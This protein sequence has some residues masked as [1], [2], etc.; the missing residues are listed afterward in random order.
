M[1]TYHERLSRIDIYEKTDRNRE[2]RKAPIINLYRKSDLPR[3]LCSRVKSHAEEI[4]DKNS[5]MNNSALQFAICVR[6][7]QNL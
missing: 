7:A 2:V 5:D 4:V 3:R 6:M 1:S